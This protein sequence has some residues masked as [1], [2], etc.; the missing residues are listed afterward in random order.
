[1]R[2]ITFCNQEMSISA[3][4]C[5]ASAR[6]YGLEPCIM[7]TEDLSDE[8]V[9]FNEWIFRQPRGVGY[10][11]WKPYIIY[12]M[13]CSMP[14]EDWLLYSDAGVRLVG[15]PQT[16]F[17][18]LDRSDEIMLFS[19][20][21]RHAEWCKM[22]V[23][24][25]INQ[26][27]LTIVPTQAGNFISMNGYEEKKQVQASNILIKNTSGMRDIVREWLLWCQMPRFID[28]STSMIPNIPTFQEHRH[29]QAILTC[30]QIKYNMPLHWFPST[31]NL[32]KREL[33]PQ[34]GYQPIFEHHRKRNHE[35]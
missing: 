3:E 14:K 15:D 18:F 4:H 12:E 30:L 17:N 23:I 5:A 35:W 31:T 1:M 10:W 34:D 6:R 8:F 27:S 7:T 25:A 32:H 16:L 22:D 20:D 33:Y 11:L 29:D 24:N 19:N 13:L 26:N 21:W 9:N 2:L 28:D